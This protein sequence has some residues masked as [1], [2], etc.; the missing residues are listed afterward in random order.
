MKQF[1]NLSN[2]E[3]LMLILEKEFG[4]WKAGS[5]EKTT[6]VFRNEIQ[7]FKVFLPGIT[8]FINQYSQFS[9]FL[10]RKNK[11][12]D[13]FSS[14]SFPEL[15][16]IIFWTSLIKYH[17]PPNENLINLSDCGDYAVIEN[18]I[19]ESIHHWWGQEIIKLN[20]HD[21]LNLLP[22]I[23]VSWREE[24]FCFD[25]AIH[26]MFVYLSV[27]ELRYKFCKFLMKESGIVLNELL[28]REIYLVLPS[29]LVKIINE[30]SAFPERGIFLKYLKIV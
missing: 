12:V 6:D 7:K 9:I 14:A 13:V 19:H 16:N 17:V 5:P 26:V 11:N 23:S 8:D 27:N 30:S 20:I 1:V 3:K 15:E 18:L 24:K 25:K 2:Q 28:S 21:K 29:E 10:Q 22:P 4:D